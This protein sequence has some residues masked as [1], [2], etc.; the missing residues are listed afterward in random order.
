MEN[1]ILYNEFHIDFSRSYEEQADSL[2]EDLFQMDLG[3]GRL[4]DIG[5]YPEFDPNGYF[6]VQ[7][8]HNGN[9]D[10]PE[11]TI[12]VRSGA[13]LLQAVKQCICRAGGIAPPI[14]PDDL[15]AM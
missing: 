4:L 10:S 3:D 9:W 7:V 14:R 15:A 1:I 6:R 11:C 13:E 2:N 8:I 5:W 12:S